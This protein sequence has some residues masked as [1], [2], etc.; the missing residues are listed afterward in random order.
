[1][2]YRNGTP[3][4]RLVTQDAKSQV[5]LDSMNATTGW[6]AGG[7]ASGL[8]Q[9]VSSYWQ[10]P[11]SLRFN[12]TVGTGTLTKAISTANLSSYQGI[13][14]AFIAVYI[15]NVSLLTSITLKLGSSASDYYSVTQT[16]GFAGALT[17]DNWLL[18]PFDFSTA[19]TTGTPDWSAVDYAQV[20]I[21]STGTLTNFHVGQLFISLPVPHQIIYQRPSIFLATGASTPTTTITDDTDSIILN[22]A[23]YNIFL[24]EAT[25]AVLENM[26]GGNGDSMYDRLCQRL[27]I[28]GQ[29]NVVG[30]LY[31]PYMAD[32]PSEQI[33]QF[34]TYYPH[35]NNWWWGN[36]TAGF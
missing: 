7:T 13:G 9:D 4:L 5:L 19:S 16:T 6:T 33:R 26:S 12:Q 23:P 29:G 25:L 35:R 3:I 2:E 32:N 20:S 21:V 27:G 1:M 14:V 17:S 10:A 28:D 11:S 36:G 24:Y 8:A 34:N 22:T 31:K 30:G 15:P 18:I